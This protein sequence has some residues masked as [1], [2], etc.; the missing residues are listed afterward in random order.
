MRRSLLAG[1]VGGSIGLSACEEPPEIERVVAPAIDR[2]ASEALK[3]SAYRE[4]LEQALP[5][6]RTALTAADPLAAY[7]LGLAPAASPPLRAADRRALERLLEPA[8]AA[9]AEIDESYLPGAEVVIVRLV[10]FGLTRLND[11]LHRRARAQRD[12]M[13]GLAAV[14]AYLDELRYRL[15]IDGCD[16]ACESLPAALAEDVGDLSRQL[17]AASHPEVVHAGAEARARA[18]EARSLAS[19]PATAERPQL[20]AGLET[21]ALACEAYASWLDELAGKLERES[22]VPQQRWTDNPKPRAVADP[23]ARLP[24][25]VGAPALVRMLSVEERIDLNPGSAFAE[26]E[27]HVARWEKLRQSMLDPSQPAISEQPAAAVGV[28][29]CEAALDRLRRGLA[30]VPEVDP[31]VL[32]CR[33]YVDLLG[34]DARTDAQLLL[35][36]LDL[37]VIEPQR[38][39]LRAAELPEVALIG[40]Q[41]STLVHT[42]LRR[43][44]LLARLSEPAATALALNEGRRALC[45]AEAALWIHAELGPPKEVALTLGG[46]CADLGDAASITAHV[47]G[48]PRAALAGFGLSLIGDEPARMVGFDRFFWAPLGTMRMLSTPKG[49]HP[50]AFTL[51]DDPGPAPE[52]KVEFNFEKL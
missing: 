8:L 52:P 11:D 49:M 31:P 6:V 36:L 15:L 21:L 38:R 7:Q 24:A 2:E 51:P 39:A 27:R 47:T 12:P 44:M 34:D 14:D 25:I 13:V 41:W 28:P 40:G 29:R 9:L 18:S 4:A 10:R 5:T 23:V 30:A 48:D 1:V 35:D 43:I 16:A 3:T 50:D 42:H 33:R 46:P 26:I 17:G 22:G 32:D 45:W 37:G 19:K 20:R